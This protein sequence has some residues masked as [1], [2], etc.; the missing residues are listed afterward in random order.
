MRNKKN[1]LYL[2]FQTFLTAFF[3]KVETAKISFG[4]T[5]GIK[6]AST[7]LVVFS[8]IA[9]WLLAEDHK[10]FSFKYRMLHICVKHTDFNYE[11]EI[12]EE[13]ILFL[14]TEPVAVSVW[15]LY[16]YLYMH[17]A[18]SELMSGTVLQDEGSQYTSD[19]T[20]DINNQ[21]ACKSSTGNWRACYFI[22]GTAQFAPTTY[23]ISPLG[24]S[25]FL[26]LTL[27]IGRASCRE[28]V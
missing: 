5:R 28:R 20:V 19:G 27:E 4:T 21:P 13:P 23:L 2:L 24:P 26:V 22:L 10:R 25:N 17:F 15:W 12:T 11:L 18:L 8:T 3:V 7:S 9:K 14:K 6:W 1:I 16:A